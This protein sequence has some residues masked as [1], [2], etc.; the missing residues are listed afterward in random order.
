MKALMVAGVSVAASVAQANLNLSA[1]SDLVNTV[2]PSE[3]VPIASSA[4]YQS[5][6]TYTGD[7]EY[8]YVFNDKAAGGFSA[9]SVYFQTVNAGVTGIDQ[10]PDFSVKD[11]IA[12]PPQI[13]TGVQPGV[14]WGF[15]NGGDTL[16]GVE[17]VDFYSPIPPTIGSASGQDGGIWYSGDVVV[18]NVPDCGL[19]MTLLGG[20]FLGLQALRRKLAR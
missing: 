12:Y 13:N 16:G 19:T 20:S 3:I 4:T 18:P 9:F 14:Q 1:N 7:Y 8:V 2:T 10:G 6:G 17:D 15:L 5:S 11:A